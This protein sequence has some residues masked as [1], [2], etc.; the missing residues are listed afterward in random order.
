MH[1][2]RLLVVLGGLAAAL[3]AQAEPPSSGVAQAAAAAAAGPL[4]YHSAFSDY[5]M[6]EETEVGNWKQRND[7]V[8]AAAAAR[9]GQ[10]VQGTPANTAPRAVTP[11]APAKGPMTA[12]MKHMDH[13]GPK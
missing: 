8:R 7:Q 11:Q 13:G 2:T 6:F 12:P 5:R 3:P 1:R 10:A 9:F 4:V